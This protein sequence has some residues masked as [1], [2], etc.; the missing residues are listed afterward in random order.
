MI[1]ITKRRCYS[2]PSF[3][4]HCVPS[5]LI[6]YFS[7]K[8]KSLINTNSYPSSFRHFSMF[9]NASGVWSASL[10]KRT[11]LPFLTLLVTLLQM[12]SG[13]AL[14]FQSRESTLDTKVKSFLSHYNI[15]NYIIFLL[16][17]QYNTPQ[18][19]TRQN[20]TTQSST[21]TTHYNPLQD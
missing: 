4:L 20:G 10:W 13:V 6:S 2:A 12:L 11:I 18:P 16:K 14:S 8:I 17:N 15:F 5:C 3:S 1:N 21:T 7:F 9:G 19:I